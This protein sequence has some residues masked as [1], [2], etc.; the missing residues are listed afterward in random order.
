MALLLMVGLTMSAHA[1]GFGRPSPEQMKERMTRQ[2]EN[3][4]TELKLEDAQTDTVK[5]ILMG[6]VDKR[7]KLVEE[8]EG[9]RRGLRE[10][11]GKVAEETEELLAGVLSDE[12]MKTY[13]TFTEQANRRRGGRRGG[14]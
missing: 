2:M 11:M 6:S 13:K 9:S 7:M 14:N 10:A 5:T 4:M 3:L 8:N 1:Q 12:Q